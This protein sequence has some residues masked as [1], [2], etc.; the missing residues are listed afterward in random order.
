MPRPSK[1]KERVRV[2]LDKRLTALSAGGCQPVLGWSH[3][4]A[5]A[6][7]ISIGM[8]HDAKTLADFINAW[9]RLEREDQTIEQLRVLLRDL[10]ALWR[11]RHLSGTAEL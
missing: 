6:T 1:Q 9:L 7:P 11:S 5:L 4:D 8:A 10:N 2:V 3:G